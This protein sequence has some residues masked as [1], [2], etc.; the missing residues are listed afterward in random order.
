MV[1]EHN[2]QQY[3]NLLK[4]GLDAALREKIAK[5]LVEEE[6]KLASLLAKEDEAP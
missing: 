2:I 6:A 3:Q 1:I 4:I 5:L